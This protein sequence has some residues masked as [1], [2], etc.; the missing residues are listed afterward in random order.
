M[1]QGSD[2]LM[3]HRRFRISDGLVLV[4]ATAVGFAWMRAL[5]QEQFDGLSL[6]NLRTVSGWTFLGWACCPLASALSLGLL[7]LRLRSPKPRW[8]RLTRQ[9]GFVACLFGAGSAVLSGI[10]WLLILTSLLQLHPH[11][12]PEDVF[13]PFW[14]GAGGATLGAWIVMLLGGTGRPEKSWLDRSGRVMGG[15]WLGLLLLTGASW[16]LNCLG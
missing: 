3:S 5:N 2:P 6:A 4:L 7:V 8:R 1:R 13:G 9:P 11:N 15:F 16:F 10:V 12:S 14:L